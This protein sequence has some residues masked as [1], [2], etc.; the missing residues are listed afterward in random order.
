V[1][2]PEGTEYRIRIDDKFHIVRRV[3]VDRQTILRRVEGKAIARME[4]QRVGKVDHAVLGEIGIG[5]MP[6]FNKKWTLVVDHLPAGSTNRRLYL[7]GDEF[8]YDEQ[9]LGIGSTARG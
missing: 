5:S 3:L 1:D 7:L 4:L 2:G 8:S 6:W 9:R